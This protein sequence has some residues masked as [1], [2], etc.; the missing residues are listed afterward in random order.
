MPEDSSQ[1][2]R[3]CPAC[4]RANAMNARTCDG[5]GASFAG[6]LVVVPEAQ[7]RTAYA[8]EFPTVRDG[9]WQGVAL[10]REQVPLPPQIQA[11]AFRREQEANRLE[12][13]RRAALE[14]Q[15]ALRREE[16][17]LLAERERAARE[18]A[19]RE[20]AA[21]VSRQKKLEE[22]EALRERLRSAKF[23]VTD[24]RSMSQTCHTCGAP[25]ELAQGV[26][27]SFCGS[28]G[29]DLVS[30]EDKSGGSAAV[31]PS[32]AAP[33]ASAVAAAFA[34]LQPQYQMEDEQQQRTVRG[35][36]SGTL[37]AQQ[38]ISAQ[39]LSVRQQAGAEHQRTFFSPA[40]CAASG[41]FVP[42]LGQ[43]LNGQGAKGLVL[44]IACLVL[45]ASAGMWGVTMVIARLLM[46]L[47]AYRIAEKRRR[48]ETIGNWEW[49]IQ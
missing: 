5:C 20:H 21:R 26:R 19:A 18:H 29:A 4:G 2:Q 35:S 1:Q 40:F 11:E 49:D 22:E 14:K 24:R 30:A 48:G 9:S 15:E 10:R 34:H 3:A 42:G 43:M 8:S 41:F 47:D 38:Q 28:C 25:A 36:A 46:A 37:S 27:F 39:H 7:K 31:A 13:E 6:R 32:A 45:S 33:T 16:E 17:R 23:T 12:A 44:L